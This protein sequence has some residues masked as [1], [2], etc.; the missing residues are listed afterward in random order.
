MKRNCTASLRL[1]GNLVDDWRQPEE[2]AVQY[3]ER[4]RWKSTP[5][6]GCGLR[7]KVL[8]LDA[9]SGTFCFQTQHVS[10]FHMLQPSF[11]NYSSNGG[12]KLL[13]INYVNIYRHKKVRTIPHEF[14]TKHSNWLQTAAFVFAYTTPPPPPFQDRHTF[15]LFTQTSWFQ[16][17]IYIQVQI[18]PKLSFITIIFYYGRKLARNNR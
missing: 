12:Y 15:F 11:V 4:F 8:N 5:L 18:L 14:K 2:R 7:K 3:E 1:T 13:L 10:L 17:D 6:W 9:F 16:M